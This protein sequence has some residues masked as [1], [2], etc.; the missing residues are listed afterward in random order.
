MLDGKQFL[1]KVTNYDDGIVN[2]S[3]ELFIH[4]VSGFQ[5]YSFD[6]SEIKNY[7]NL[8]LGA[9]QKSFYSN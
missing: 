1:G 7:W 2:N 8:K 5:L 6:E 4:F 9:G 3:G